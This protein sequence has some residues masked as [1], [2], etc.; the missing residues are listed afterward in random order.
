MLDFLLR[1]YNT[2]FNIK[3]FCYKLLTDQSIQQ[4]QKKIRDLERI[5]HDLSSNNHDLS[6][7]NQILKHENMQLKDSLSKELS[8][9]S[10]RQNLNIPVNADRASLLHRLETLDDIISDETRLHAATLQSSKEFEVILKQFEDAIKKSKDAPL[11]RNNEKRSD[12]PGNRCSL[13][14]RHA[15]L[16]YLLRLKDNPTQGTLE[17]FFGIDQSTVCRYLQFCNE[18]LKETLPTPDRIS[19]AMSKC[20]TVKGIKEFVPGRGAGTLLVDG[21]HI[22][23]DRPGEK[24]ERKKTYTGKKKNHTNNTTIISTTDNIIVGISKTAVGSTHDLKMIKE[25]SIPFGRWTRKMRDEDTPAKEKFTMYMDLG[26]QGIQK[27]FPG[28]NVVLPHKKPRKKKTDSA[29]PKLTKEQKA[30][31]K[32]VGGIRVTVEN[33]IGRIKQYSRMTEPYGGT[34]EELNAEINIVAGLV[35][36]HLMMTLQRG[37]ASLRKRFLG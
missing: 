18:M 28:V 15:L 14:P 35:N 36:L 1:F 6:S 11:F 27:Y 7:N 25:H 31:N 10:S 33:S 16:M 5:N 22:R 21:T 12:D 13:Y 9:W 3:L 26:Y 34:E 24:E 30:Y 17:A 4:F 29:A 37:S 2:L 32:K 20:K 19:K 8:L 23:V